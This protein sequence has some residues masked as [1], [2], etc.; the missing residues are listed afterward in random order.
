VLLTALE[1]C[2]VGRLKMCIIID[3]VFLIMSEWTRWT[4]TSDIK[5]Y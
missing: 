4:E 1:K 2:T 5:I 3:K